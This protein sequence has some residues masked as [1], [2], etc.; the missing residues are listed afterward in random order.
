MKKLRYL[1]LA[2]PL[3]VGLY[4]AVGRDSSPAVAAPGPAM[5]AELVA[6]GRVEPVRDPVTLSFEQQGRIAEVLVDEGEAVVAGQVV[7]RLDDRMAKAR[8]DAATAMLA[9]AEARYSLARRGPRREDVAAARADADAAS[10]AATHRAAEQART[11]ELGKVGAVTTQAVDADGAAAR[12]AT[13]QASAASARYESLAKGTRAEQIAEASASVALA[14]AELDAATVALDQHSLRAPSAGVI[15]R[16][17]AEPGAFV[18]LA[19]PAPVLAMADVSHLQLRLEVDEADIAA[20]GVGQVA[21]ATTDAHGDRRFP[22]RLRRVS[23][24]LGR[25]TVRDDDP[26]ARV[27]TRVL[28]VIATFDEAPGA[29]LP[30]GLRMTAHVAH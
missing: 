25:K 23:A 12:V 13:A 1:A 16:R 30:V 28:E 18:T 17:T 22:I 15:L 8:V 2:L 9:Q 26:R 14:K 5:P 11:A 20:I 4:V 29:T 27:D 21:Y 19:M 3:A 7:A 10:A 6:P 24:E